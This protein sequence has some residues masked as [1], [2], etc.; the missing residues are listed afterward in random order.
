MISPDEPISITVPVAHY[1]YGDVI[2]QQ[3]VEFTISKHDNRFKAIPLIS[4]EERHATGL[5]HELVF[6]YANYCIASANYMHEE[7]LN[8]IKQIIQELDVQELL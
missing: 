8:A 4:K 7:A 6:V 2:S 1:Q 3:A 5:P